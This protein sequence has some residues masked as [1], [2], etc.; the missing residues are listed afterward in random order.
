MFPDHFKGVVFVSVAVVDSDTFKGTSEIEALETRTRTNLE[1]YERFGR[2]LGLPS[3]SRYAVGTEVAVEGE[4][5]G[6][7]LLEKYPKALVVA[8]QLIFEEDSTWNRILHNETAFLIQRRLQH[9]GVPM[10]VLPVQLD[11]KNDDRKAPRPLLPGKGP[12]SLRGSA[13]KRPELDMADE[14]AASGP[15]A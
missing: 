8:G 14:A 12:L 13:P 2:A 11:L 5:L 10:I 7:A 4:H 3:A 9:V 6:T 15:A 1:A